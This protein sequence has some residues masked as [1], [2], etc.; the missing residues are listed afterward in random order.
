ELRI[1]LT[2]IGLDRLTKQPFCN[3]APALM[4]VWGSDHPASRNHIASP[5]GSGLHLDRRAFDEALASAARVAGA[6]L[7]LGHAAHFV[8]EAGK[9]YAVLLEGG[10]RA[11]A[12]FAILATGRTGGNLG[13]PY[14]RRYLDDNI[15]VAAHFDS[16]IGTVE[17]PTL[18]EATRGGWF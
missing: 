6:D 1:A 7:K 8:P 10:E 4:S 12:N 5:Y 3:D 11:H 13:L 18:V 14:A 2:R 9:G 16:P 17:M 15:A